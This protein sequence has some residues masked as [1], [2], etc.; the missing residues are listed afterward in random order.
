MSDGVKPWSI[1]GADLRSRT[2]DPAN[3]P[4]DRSHLI[5]LVLEKQRE[6]DELQQKFEALREASFEDRPC[7]RLRLGLPCDVCDRVKER[8]RGSAIGLASDLVRQLGELAH[9]VETAERTVEALGDIV[10]SLRG[11]R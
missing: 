7:A 10:H 8:R 9:K 11:G 2:G 6:L 4:D 5:D 1:L 3:A